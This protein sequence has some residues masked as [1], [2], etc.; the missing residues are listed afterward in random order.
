M[1]RPLVAPATIK[2]RSLSWRRVARGSARD[3]RPLPRDDEHELVFDEDAPEEQ[4]RAPH[5]SPHG[6]RSRTWLWGTVSSLCEP[7]Q[8]IAADVLSPSPP[9]EQERE[10]ERRHRLRL[11]RHEICPSIEQKELQCVS[12]RLREAR[13]RHLNAKAR[14]RTSRHE[15][16][17]ESDAVAPSDWACCGYTE[18]R[19]ER[20][21]LRAPG[22][23][24]VPARLSANSLCSC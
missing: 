3:V 17:A 22:H 20:G 21:R 19:G 8:Q 23:A 16:R 14:T 13:P 1:R 18:L 11:L 9:V 10:Q 4:R 24:G 2:A 6:G 12:A 15:T 5:V 7:R